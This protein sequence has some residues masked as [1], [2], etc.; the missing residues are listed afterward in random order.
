MVTASRQVC[1]ECL[2]PLINVISYNH[3]PKLLI[4]TVGGY[5]IEISKYIKITTNDRSMKLYLKGIVYFG[6]FHFVSR[7]IRKDDTVWFHDG[8]MGSEC[9]YD[10]RLEDFSNSDLK[11][12]GKR[13]VSIVIYA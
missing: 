13:T 11:I 1:P 3:F 5:N 8:Q 10:K 9:I 4:F 2:N 6:G 7:I 12:C